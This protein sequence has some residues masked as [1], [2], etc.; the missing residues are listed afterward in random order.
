[1]WRPCVSRSWTWPV[2]AEVGRRVANI[3]LGERSLGPADFRWDGTGSDGRR[4]I[5]GTYVWRL[6]VAADAF[7]EEH[8][9]ILVIAY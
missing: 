9:G 3:D 7:D 4:L 5:P 8:L 1:M 6:V 2:P